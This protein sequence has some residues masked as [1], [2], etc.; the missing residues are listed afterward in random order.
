MLEDEHRTGIALAGGVANGS[1]HRRALMIEKGAS[2]GR[3]LELVRDELAPTFKELKG[4]SGRDLIFVKEDL[5]LPHAT[6]F[7]DLITTRARETA[8]VRAVRSEEGALLVLQ[9]P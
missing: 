3:F 7:Y 6:T 1:G 5:M 4:V 8:R 2:V 9:C